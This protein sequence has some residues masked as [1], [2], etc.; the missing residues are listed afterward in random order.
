MFQKLKNSY[1]QWGYNLPLMI[2]FL[3]PFGVNYAILIMLWAICFFAFDDVKQGL[4]KVFTNKW[5]YVFIGFFFLHAIAYF[6]SVNKHEAL[7]SIEIKLSFFA[8]PILIFSSNYSDIQVKKIAITFVTGCILACMICLFRAF[9]L[10]Y[11]QDFN[12]F[13]Y[14]EFTYFMHPS[15]FAMYLVLAQ[16]MVML[17]YK[18]WLAHLTNLNFKIGFISCVLLSGIFLAS[19]KMGLASAVLILPTVLLAMFYKKGYKKSIIAFLLSIVVVI[20]V[21]YKLVPSYFERIKTAISVTS[22]AE[23]IDKTATE[24]TAVRIL[25]WEESIKLIKENFLFGT[26]PGDANDEL[27]KAYHASGM[28]GASKK[29][30]NAHN[31]FFQTFIGSGL[32]GFVLLLIMTL[33]A[34]VYG[35]VKRNSLLSLFSALMIL[36]F[37]VESMLQ[38][39]AGFI[40]FVFFI[41]LFLKYNFSTMSK[42][43]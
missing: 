30:L 40:F 2:S 16:L 5:T 31:Q 13:F 38:A 39:Q 34:L 32:I 4:K 41:C 11:F 20:S 7:T 33:G 37:L 24:S 23:M 17:Y 19:S 21:A 27:Q 9:Y 18:Q 15:Y 10:F 22:S 1:Q 29:N 42:N 35:L 3:L 43:S 36:N 28:T 26:T 14:S 25:I 12:A 6:F 8:F